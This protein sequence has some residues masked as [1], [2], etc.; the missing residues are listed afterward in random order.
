M[1]KR[2]KNNTDKEWNHVWEH[3]EEIISKQEIDKRIISTLDRMKKQ[4]EGKKPV[5]CWSGGKDAQA[6][7]FLYEMA[8]YDNFVMG[9]GGEIEY[10]A[11]LEWA[12]KYKPEN[13]EVYQKEIDF[14]YLNKHE[15]LIFP[16]KSDAM[17]WYYQNVN[18]YA[19]FQYCKEHGTDTL[20]SGHRIKDGNNCGTDGV[21][22]KGDITQIFPIYDWTHEEVF[23]LLHY[24]HIPIPPIYKWKKGFAE[25]T[26]VVLSRSGKEGKEKAME[27]IMEID[28]TILPRLAGKIDI[29]R[30]YCKQH[31]LKG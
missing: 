13:T 8:G 11:F 5:C 15:E 29:I 17:Y 26:H 9:S 18:Q 4:L 12:E 27:E 6:V 21:K 25:G 3:I 24:Y 10:P 7:R 16:E 2:K 20:V 14:D 23:A 31:Q 30:D 19:W 1:L 28:P 22:T